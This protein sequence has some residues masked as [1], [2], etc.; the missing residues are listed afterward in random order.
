[1]FVC[2]YITLETRGY[3]GVDG[4]RSANHLT[5]RYEWQQCNWSATV[6]STWFKRNIIDHYCL[7]VEILFK[8]H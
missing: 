6:S 8:I 3:K 7:S 2:V 4:I 1:L 5:L